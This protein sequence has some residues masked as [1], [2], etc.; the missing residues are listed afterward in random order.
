MEGEYGL[1][2]PTFADG[3]Q[4]SRE[5]FGEGRKVMRKG[6]AYGLI[7]SPFAGSNKIEDPAPIVR[8]SDIGV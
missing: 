1:S 4:R 2:S 5:I 7:T 3:E 6:T 8:F